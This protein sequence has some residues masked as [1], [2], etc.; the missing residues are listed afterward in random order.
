MGRQPHQT[1]LNSLQKSLLCVNNDIYFKCV[2]VI[3]K[4]S[5]DMF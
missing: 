2:F 4:L 5:I 3:M 1:N